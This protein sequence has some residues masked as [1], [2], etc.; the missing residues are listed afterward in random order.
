[1]K[2]MSFKGFI[3][4]CSWTL[5]GLVDAPGLSG[6]ETGDTKMASQQHA[7]EPVRSRVRANEPV[8]RQ[9]VDLH[10]H[11]NGTANSAAVD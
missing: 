10:L 6:E 7:G 5:I 11:T 3:D 4:S 2:G 8:R 9:Q 1:M